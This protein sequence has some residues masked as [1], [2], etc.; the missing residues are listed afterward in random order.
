MPGVVV[1]TAVRTGPSGAGEVP[2]AQWFVAGTTERGPTDEPVLVRSMSEYVS[3][4]G[5]YVSGNLYTHVQT[6][7]E[8]GGGRAYVYRVTGANASA[9]YLDLDDTNTTATVRITAADVGAWSD[10]IEVEVVD[11]DATDT[12][13]LKVY[14][15]SELLYTSRDLVNPADAVAVINTS[16]VSHL[17]VASDLVSG[18]TPPD[19]NPVVLS[20]TALSAGYDG[21]A[22][23]D[24]D[25]TNG[26][27][28]F[29]YD[30]GPGSVALPGQT[31]A[32]QWAALLDHAKANH[33]IAL[34]A[35][36]ETDTI[37]TVKTSVASMYS[38]DAAD[39][40][41]FYFPWVTIPDPATAG[42]TLNQSPEAFAA[43]ARSKSVT[44]DG[45]WMPGA[46]LISE[47]AFVT[48]AVTALNSAEGDGLDE[49]RINAIR[50]IGGKMRVYGARSVSA[51]EVNWRYITNRDTVNYVAWGAE[52]RLEDFVFSTIDARGA[53][54]ARIES[55]LIGLLDPIRLAGGLYEAFDSDGN[56][57][58]PG[59]SVQVD[60]TIN[61]LNNLAEG[62]ITANVNIR[63]SS[64]GDQIT[65]TV[66]KSNLTTSVV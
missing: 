14:L 36:D 63:V 64:V 60:D 19:D 30:L 29:T 3:Y 16:T 18:S 27:D 50:K 59:Y 12:F 10:S 34:C 1:T 47:A 26:L 23:T 31:G 46:G 57:V 28:N 24:A 54:F 4:F 33:R 15:K 17:V 20:A 65:V 21:D 39:Y 41:A 56:Q 37:S 7:F 52:E 11:G 53:L 62:K 42:L 49:K 40:G 5:D 61:P 55:A 22:L 44:Q 13:K 32:T 8:E 38:D 6:Y 45:P 35:F 58:D 66:T 51:D 48:G 25:Y 2:A 9:G 43:A